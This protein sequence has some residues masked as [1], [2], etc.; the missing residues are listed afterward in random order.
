VR[1]KVLK[2]ITFEIGLENSVHVAD[3]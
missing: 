3:A 2:M 1:R